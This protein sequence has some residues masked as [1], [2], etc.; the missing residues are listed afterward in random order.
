MSLVRLGASGN[1]GRS[2]GRAALDLAQEL[3]D[4]AAAIAGRPARRLPDL[5][6]PAAGDVLAVCANDLAE[7]L[8]AVPPEVGASTCRS[9]VERLVSLR[10][11]L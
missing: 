4:E 6:D 7:E 9:A 10:Q 8:D 11:L 1:D 3:A 5:P 2:R